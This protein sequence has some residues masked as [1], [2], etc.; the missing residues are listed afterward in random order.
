MLLRNTYES[1]LSSY[2]GHEPDLGELG[3]T[4]LHTAVLNLNGDY[5]FGEVIES[6]PRSSIDVKDRMGSTPLMWAVS[7]GYLDRARRLLMKG[8]D[9]DARDLEGGSALL[10]ALRFRDFQIVKLLLQS[11]ANYTSINGKDHSLLHA[12]VYAGVNDDIFGLCLHYYKPAELRSK[13]GGTALIEVA[14]EKN[15]SLGPHCCWSS[16]ERRNFCR[17]LHAGADTEVRRN[18]FRAVE[19]ALSR[20][21]HECI[22]ELLKHYVLCENTK[23][24]TS[25]LHLDQLSWKADAKSLKMLRVMPLDWSATT[26]E[27][28]K[29]E[30]RIAIWRSTCNGEYAQWRARGGI[31]SEDVFVDEDPQAWFEAFKALYDDA[32]EQIDLQTS[33]LITDGALLDPIN[34]P[35]EDPSAGSIGD[36]N[37]RSIPGSFPCDE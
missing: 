4:R 7:R 36:E 12:A 20:N 26:H 24:L 27:D 17:L 32:V 11:G 2:F 28:W 30:L 34:E 19:Y 22:E 33:S 5:T 21:Y 10:Y 23:T 15:K 18:E 16:Q 25:G 6:M 37:A 29:Q 3:F 14:A 1:S 35:A 8:A 13:D 31:F 9:P